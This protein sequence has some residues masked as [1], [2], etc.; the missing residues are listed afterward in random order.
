MI[1]KKGIIKVRDDGIDFLDHEYNGEEFER[2]YAKWKRD[3]R[4]R[5]KIESKKHN[6]N[7]CYMLF[8]CFSSPLALDDCVLR[9]RDGMPEYKHDKELRKI[10]KK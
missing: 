8:K 7:K 1:K 3:F 4:L 2:L 10:T 6:I 9:G 5:E